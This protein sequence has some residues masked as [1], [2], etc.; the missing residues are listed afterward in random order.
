MRSIDNENDPRIL[1]ELS[2]LQ[3]AEIIRLQNLFKK[4]ESEKD[5]VLQ[6]KF[7]I[8]ESL[9]IL[10]KKVFG[11]SSEKSEK[12]EVDDFDR[13]RSVEESELI[14]HSQNIVPPLSKKQTKKLDEE[15]IY[16]ELSEDELKKVSVEMSLENAS[17]SQWEKQEGLVDE[18]VMVTV[19]E[20]KFFTKSHTSSEV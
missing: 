10:R 12:H 13:L 15:I 20:R 17:A 16:A 19:V 6:Q 3:H 5:E 1:T 2:K 8:D 18:L 4:F 14:L 9:L 11:K 7:S